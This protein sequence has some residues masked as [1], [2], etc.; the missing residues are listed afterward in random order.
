M[1]N[2]EIVKNNDDTHDYTHR[3]SQDGCIVMVRRKDD[4]KSNGLSEQFISFL[5]DYM[6]KGIKAE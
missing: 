5:L 6:D 1:D 2:K 4:K 3:Y